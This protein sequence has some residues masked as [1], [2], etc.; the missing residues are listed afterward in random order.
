MPTRSVDVVQAVLS[1]AY[2]CPGSHRTHPSAFAHPGPASECQLLQ[3]LQGGDGVR[4]GEAVWIFAPCL[5]QL[6][7]L[8]TPPRY[9]PAFPSICSVVC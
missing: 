6:S 4:G 1:L 9:P 2:H 7:S 8:P 3:H 5:C